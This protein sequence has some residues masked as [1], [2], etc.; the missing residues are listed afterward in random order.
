M[1][2][3]AAMMKLMKYAKVFASEG[4]GKHMVKFVDPVI[5]RYIAEEFRQAVSDLDQIRK[6]LRMED[7]TCG[8]ALQQTPF[9]QAVLQYRELK[10]PYG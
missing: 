4:V 9:S 2:I 1:T 5:Y 8:Q 10:M 6:H 7:E 3:G